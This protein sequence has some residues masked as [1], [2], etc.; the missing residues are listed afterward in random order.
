MMHIVAAAVLL[1]VSPGWTEKRIDSENLTR[2]AE[3]RR[4]RQL[5][6]NMIESIT[7]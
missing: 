3:Y 1:A 7:A 4:R 2:G 5:L 6:K